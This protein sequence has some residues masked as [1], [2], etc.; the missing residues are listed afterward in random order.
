MLTREAL[1]EIEQRHK[2]A[3]HS[4][5]AGDPWLVLFGRD[6]HFDRR[7]LL[8]HIAEL[9][10]RMAAAVEEI[11]ELRKLAALETVR[12]GKIMLRE[13]EARRLAE[14]MAANLHKISREGQHYCG[15]CGVGATYSDDGQTWTIEHDSDCPVAAYRAHVAGEG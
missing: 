2:A 10:A 8:A 14:A 7:D 6:A 11:T 1:A 12:V 5:G 13:Q 3:T 9:D 4:P 15:I